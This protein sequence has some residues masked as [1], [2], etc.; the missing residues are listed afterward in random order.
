MLFILYAF[1]IFVPSIFIGIITKVVMSCPPLPK[2]K[3]VALL[4]LDSMKDVLSVLKLA[5]QELGEILSALE[6]MD[7]AILNLVGRQYSIPIQNSQDENFPFTILVETQGSN[8]IHDAEKVESFLELCMER[9][10]VKDG[11][12]CQDES[13]AEEM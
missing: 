1:F 12:L 11:I 13:Q 10:Y 8:R 5:K 2:S 4:G 9:E 3:H 7:Q 6:L